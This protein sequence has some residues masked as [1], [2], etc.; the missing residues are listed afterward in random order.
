MEVLRKAVYYLKISIQEVDR[1]LPVKSGVLK[2]CLSMFLPLLFALLLDEAKG[3]ADRIQS[4]CQI[5]QGLA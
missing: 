2:W 4:G 5:G 3:N 1:S